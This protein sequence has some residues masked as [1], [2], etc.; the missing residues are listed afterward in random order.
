MSWKYYQAFLNLE[1]TYCMPQILSFSIT[2]QKM[3]LR[4]VRSFSK[5]RLYQMIEFQK[6]IVLLTNFNMQP[7]IP[8][9]WCNNRKFSGSNL[10]LYKRLISTN[11]WLPK[12]PFLCVETYERQQMYKSHFSAVFSFFAVCE[13]NSSFW[14]THKWCEDCRKFYFLNEI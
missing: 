2:E 7:E 13:E 4:F 8:W 11:F 9:K 6:G 14:K 10:S 1:E 12:K 5:F 3:N